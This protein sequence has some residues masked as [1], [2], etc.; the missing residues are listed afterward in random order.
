MCFYV[1]NP[2]D[3]VLYVF[4]NLQLRNAPGLLRHDHAIMVRWFTSNALPSMDI[5][6]GNQSF[7]YIKMI[8]FQLSL[9]IYSCFS[10]CFTIATTHASSNVVCI[11]TL[12]FVL[13]KFQIHIVWHDLQCFSFNKI[14]CS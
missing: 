11:I 6:D 4:F 2:N 1:L 3:T 13:L 14:N 5:G 9:P 10:Y 7:F 8:G 12:W